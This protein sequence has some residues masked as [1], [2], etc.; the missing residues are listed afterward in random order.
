MATSPSLGRSFGAA[1]P[2]KGTQVDYY[3]STNRCWI[4]A[5][6]TNV[7]AETG[8]VVID[9]KPGMELSLQQQKCLLRN[10]TRPSPERLGQLQAMLREGRVED[11]VEKLFSRYSTVPDEAQTNHDEA[12]FE[13]G[14]GQKRQPEP[15]LYQ[16][17]IE[18]I[19]TKVDLM[20]GVTGC[21]LAFRNAYERSDGEGVFMGQF[22]EI[23]WDMLWDVQKEYCMALRPDNRARRR[24]EVPTALYDFKDHLGAGAYGSVRLA[25]CKATNSKCAVKIMRKADSSADMRMMEQELTL[26][27]LMDH[28]NIVRLNEVFETR[29]EVHMVMSYCSG[30][31]LEEAIQRQDDLRAQF[32][33]AYCAGI[34]QQVLSAITH[35]HAR[36][37]V[38]QD[39]KPANLM[40]MPNKVTIAPA[41]NIPTIG[42]LYSQLPHV[43]VIDLGVATVFRPGNFRGNY[44]IGTPFTMAPEVWKGEVTPKAD[45]F[46][47]GVVLFE[48]M[49]LTIPHRVSDDTEA[50]LAYWATKPKVNWPCVDHRSD[51]AV[52]LCRHMMFLDRHKRPTAKGCLGYEWVEKLGDVAQIPMRS[53]P[54]QSP[55][56][57]AR[58][59][60]RHLARTPQ[61]SVLHRSVAYK[62]A[63]LW[64]ANQ[65]PTVRFMYQLLDVEHYGRL[66]RHVLAKGLGK[67][68]IDEVDAVAAA[69]AMDL[70][71]NGIV[72]WTEF[73]AACIHLG[74]P[75]MEEDLHRIF[76]QVDTD[77]DGLLSRWD[78]AK[79]LPDEHQRAGLVVDCFADVVGRTE[80]GARVDWSTFLH[81]FQDLEPCKAKGASSSLGL[82]PAEAAAM[83]RDVLADLQ[84]D[85]AQDGVKGQASRQ[86]KP[87]SPRRSATPVQRR[88]TRDGTASRR[89]VSA[90]STACAHQA[91]ADPA[92]GP[93]FLA[94]MH[95]FLDRAAAALFPE[96][97]PDEVR[98]QENLQKL[99][100]MGLTDKD[101]NLMALKKYHN[102]LS[103]D[104]V[105]LI[106]S[107][108]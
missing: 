30:G 66:D 44:P 81:Y 75:D 28:P 91:D 100:D 77:G 94:Q 37:I 68:G 98:Y 47:M 3:S 26:L 8:N 42:A 5:V 69:E 20:L 55:E 13:L 108:S 19:S 27:C 21:V 7:D 4:P 15:R 80:E 70:N 32:T 54:Q 34:M 17:A 57:V 46:S 16:D 87:I 52:H 104:V 82:D 22:T 45:V 79:L 93:Q 50:A 92:A 78:L 51:A 86:R 31:S 63:N 58:Q 71:C 35:V 2:V 59:V 84:L 12:V 29:E 38:H 97:V 49:C 106:I 107:V 72:E 36:G 6:I 89:Q 41:R 43:H 73:V 103:A 65:L 11:E 95:S 60:A 18:E 90:P 83:V 14:A 88:V 61:R 101:K 10:R 25:V 76:L 56:E 9:M 33:E 105:D 24:N 48:L 67:L 96:P 74:D 62:I 53:V 40:L 1:Y 85:D 102:I 39:I 99:T 64:P 23:F